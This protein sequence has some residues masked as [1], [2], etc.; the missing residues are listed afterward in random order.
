MPILVPID[1]VDSENKIKTDN[2]HFDIF[3]PLVSF[4]QFWSTKESK[5]FRELS[6]KHAYQVW[7][8]LSWLFRRR[9]LTCKNLPTTCDCNTS[10]N[11]MPFF[12]TP[13]GLLFLLCFLINKLEAYMSLYRSPVH[14]CNLCSIQFIF[15][16]KELFYSFPIYGPMLI[17]SPSKVD[18]WSSHIS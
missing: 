16:G 8:K 3:G 4:V 9:I 7:F 1:S 15:S 13:L 14:S 11:L 18:F 5:L 6:N 17:F 2:S 12:F 10:H